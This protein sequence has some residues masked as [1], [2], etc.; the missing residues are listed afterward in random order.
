MGES[1][2]AMLAQD[3]LGSL[4]VAVD[5]RSTDRTGEILKTL[6][7][8]DPSLLSVLRVTELPDDRLGENHALALGAAEIRSDWLLFT[9]ADLT[10]PARA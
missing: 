4:A 9:D 8:E 7:F 2:H 3:Y 6:D 1:V 5:D 10:F